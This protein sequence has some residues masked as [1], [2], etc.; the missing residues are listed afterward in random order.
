MKNVQKSI[1]RDIEEYQDGYCHPSDNGF[2]LHKNDKQ[3]YEWTA[4]QAGLLTCPVK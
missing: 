3:D 2:D 1:D 4:E